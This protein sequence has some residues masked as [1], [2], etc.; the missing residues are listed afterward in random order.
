MF[1]L[2]SLILWNITQIVSAGRVRERVYSAALRPVDN[3]VDSQHSGRLFVHV[4]VYVC[5][6]ARALDERTAKFIPN[7]GQ[8][9]PSLD[10][11]QRLRFDINPKREIDTIKYDI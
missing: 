9:S 10:I 5:V 1:R 8:Y 3:A 11:R 7:K 6:C 4:F 2:E